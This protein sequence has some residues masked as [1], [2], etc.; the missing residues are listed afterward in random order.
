MTKDMTFQ[1]NLVRRVQNYVLGSSTPSNSLLPLWEAV[2]NSLHAI[3][4]RYGEKWTEQGEI[5]IS[6]IDPE[7][8]NL[9]RAG[10]AGDRLV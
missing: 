2:Y 3:Q 7:S 6:L 4:D 8:N 10:F 9:N 5:D 1:A